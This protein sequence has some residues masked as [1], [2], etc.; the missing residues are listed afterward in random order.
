MR[1]GG[2]PRGS[3]PPE[4]VESFSSDFRPKHGDHEGLIQWSKMSYILVLQRFIVSKYRGGGLQ[5][6]DFQTFLWSI[7]PPFLVFVSFV[8]FEFIF[9][10][11]FDYGPGHLVRISEFWNAIL[12]KKISSG[13]FEIKLQI[14][15][16][17]G[18]FAKLQEYFSQYSIKIQ[19]LLEFFKYSK[20][21]RG[22]ARVC[23][24]FW[25]IC[26]KIW[27]IVYFMEYLNFN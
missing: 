23:P 3:L 14:T 20:F 27:S 1:R 21:L 24:K 10:F 6:E 26:Y 18:V 12:Q 7:L 19:K 17:D 13:V 4:A 22:R 16:K 11:E 2:R 15:L 25:S 9:K 5:S 8:S